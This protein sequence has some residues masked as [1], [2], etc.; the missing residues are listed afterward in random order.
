MS[1]PYDELVDQLRLV[2]REGMEPSMV[3]TFPMTP[4]ERDA[5]EAMLADFEEKFE[6]EHE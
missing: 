1:K 2:Q 4:E 6:A 3:E 5:F